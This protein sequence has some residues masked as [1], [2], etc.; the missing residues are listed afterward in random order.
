M[1]WGIYSLYSLH[2][3]FKAAR[4]QQQGGGMWV[5]GNC[6]TCSPRK[7]AS[8]WGLQLTNQHWKAIIEKVEFS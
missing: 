2:G 5:S 8:Y 4:A 1:S 3:Q 7:V 6:G